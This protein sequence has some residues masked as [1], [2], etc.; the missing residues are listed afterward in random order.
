[1]PERRDK[2]VTCLTFEGS[3][4]EAVRFYV[5]LFDDSRVVETTYYGEGAP[6]PA[7]EVMTMQFDLQGRRFMAIHGGPEFPFSPGISLV[8]YCDTQEEL[9]RVWDALCDGG[10]PM[11]CGWLTDRFG[12][13]WQIV[14][15]VLPELM[16]GDRA[17][18]DR[19]MQA[20]WGMVKL[21]LRALE[22]A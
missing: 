10:A 20:L 7:G 5:S 6:K 4:E 16:A 17:R 9:D 1:M 3:P 11:A 8:A 12:V 15:S 22:E 18:A 2:V 21:D 13:A 19:V 14:P